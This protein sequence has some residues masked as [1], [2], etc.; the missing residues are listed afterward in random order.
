MN[1]LRHEMFALAEETF[2]EK[3]F[4]ENDKENYEKALKRFYDNYAEGDALCRR[5]VYGEIIDSSTLQMQIER[6]IMSYK[7]AKQSR[8]ILDNGNM[9]NPGDS[10]DEIETLSPSEMAEQGNS[11]ISMS[12]QNR[13]LY[14]KGTWFLHQASF[15]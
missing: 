15:L 1:E 6:M 7:F 11:M 14:E 12:S 5:V 8:K 9:F 3:Y 13:E 10:E 2:F 4:I